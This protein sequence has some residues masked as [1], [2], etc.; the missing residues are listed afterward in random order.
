MKRII[1]SLGLMIA[2]LGVGAVVLP[3]PSALAINVFNQCAP[4]DPANPNDPSNTAVCKAQGTD[5]ATSMVTTIINTLLYILG[6]IAVIMIIVGGI[7]YTT[8]NGESAG[9]KGAKDTITY[10]VIG[11][12]VAILAYAVVNFVVGIF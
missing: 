8:S 9:I 3:A 5:N 12:V 2:L 4:I 1:S 6:I 7:R 11:L 10:A